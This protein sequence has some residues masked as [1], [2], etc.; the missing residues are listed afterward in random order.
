[1]IGKTKTGKGFGGTLRYCL[2][3][4]K[5][6]VILELNGLSGENPND[7][8]RQF[9]AICD[10]NRD[11]SKPVWHTSLSFPKED[12]MSIDKMQEIANKFIEKAGF[13]KENN[14]YAIIMHNNTAH[15]HCHII[16]N[17]VGY[18]GKAVS[19]SFS[20]TRTVFFSKQ[21]ENEYNLT[22][23][24]EIFKAREQSKPRDKVP[25]REQTK[26]QLREAIDKAVKQPEIKTLQDLSQELKKSG[27]DMQILK[28]SQT[29]K[30][31][32]VSF[33]LNNIAFKGSELGKDFSF[34][35]LS[36]SVSMVK[37]IV[38]T[39]GKIISKGIEFG[40]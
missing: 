3:E 8:S 26:I 6:S 13:S 31:Y 1:M 20:K 12:Y 18:D 38:K 5:D 16:A 2:E 37:E 28:H 17:R 25:I 35:A 39:I 21:L 11:I 40:M 19:D 22:R 14:Q 36:N 10:E 34:K 23:A 29:G 7:L 24:Q 4:N 15:T 32:G 33:R 9:Q 27:I 30:E